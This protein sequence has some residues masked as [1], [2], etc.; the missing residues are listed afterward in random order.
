MF[1]CPSANTERPTATA[2]DARCSPGLFAA[3]VHAEERRIHAVSK[4][5]YEARLSGFGGFKD[6]GVDRGGRARRPSPVLSRQ[7]QEQG[8]LKARRVQGGVI[9]QKNGKFPVPGGNDQLLAHLVAGRSLLGLDPLATLSPI[10]SIMGH[11]T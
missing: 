8:G 9:S 10:S 6:R 3:R 1:C 5:I 11:A 4:Y 7:E 2:P